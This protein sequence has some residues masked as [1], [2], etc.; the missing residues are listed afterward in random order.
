MTDDTT[1]TPRKTNGAFVVLNLTPTQ[2]MIL[3]DMADDWSDKARH[4]ELRTG[5]NYTD[6]DL[7][8]LSALVQMIHDAK[9]N[10]SGRPAL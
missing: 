7:D 1:G 9:K 6:E 4:G 2:L 3:N 8:D 10:P 5:F